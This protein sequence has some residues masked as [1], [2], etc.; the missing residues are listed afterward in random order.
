[1]LV[2]LA[3]GD[4]YRAHSQEIAQEIAQDLSE[5]LVM[6]LENRKYGRDYLAALDEQLLSV[7]RAGG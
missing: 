7:V 4:A 6:T 5:D 1:M 2:E 3:V